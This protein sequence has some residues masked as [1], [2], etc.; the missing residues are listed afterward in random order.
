VVSGPFHFREFTN[1]EREPLEAMSSQLENVSVTDRP[2][3]SGVPARW[4][5]VGHSLASGEN[6]SALSVTALCGCRAPHMGF[7]LLGRL[8]TGVRV[9]SYF[10]ILIIFLAYRKITKFL[11]V[12]LIF[13]HSFMTLQ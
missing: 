7:G 1:T 6:I 9:C 13:I 3:V 5:T 4:L 11:V 2:Y 10:V 12:L 8:R